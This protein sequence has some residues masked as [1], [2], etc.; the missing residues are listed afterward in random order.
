M[1]LEQTVLF[2]V[3]RVDVDIGCFVTVSASSVS[4]VRTCW[5]VIKLT[6]YQ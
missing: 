4:T 5:T 6:I 2:N 3:L 1:L